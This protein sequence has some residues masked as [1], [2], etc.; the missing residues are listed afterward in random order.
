[1]PAAQDFERNVMAVLGYTL[2]TS[3]LWV[4]TLSQEF[5]FLAFI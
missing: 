1:M 2:R 5:E 4:A 3:G